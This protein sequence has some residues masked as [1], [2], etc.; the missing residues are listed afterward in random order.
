MTIICDTN[1]LVSALAFP[2]GIPDKILKSIFSGRV[3]HATTP[4][5]LTE[6]KRV[7]LE[8]IALEEKDAERSVT[9]IVRNSQ[10][11][12]PRERLSVIKSDESDNRLLEAVEASSASYLVT[13]D[14]K[15]LLPL[16]NYKSCLILSPRDFAAKVGLV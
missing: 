5:I 16:K 10:L 7:L 1:V 8:K 9:L 11:V 13:G 14:K 6:L 3:R 12:Y 15:H 2:G 4:D